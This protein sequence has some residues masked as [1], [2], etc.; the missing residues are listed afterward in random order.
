LSCI[1]FII[2]YIRDLDK[3]ALLFCLKLLNKAKEK[4][5]EKE[6]HIVTKQKGIF[7]SVA[8]I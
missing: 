7:S 3:K 8:C 1:K 4:E 2:F 6:M 5:K